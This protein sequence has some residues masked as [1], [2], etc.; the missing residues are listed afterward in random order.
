MTSSNSYQ[1]GIATSVDDIILDAFERCGF[2]G[3]MISGLQMQ[4]ARRSLNFLFSELS[5]RQINL[6][7][8][9]QRILGL[10]TNQISYQ[11]PTGLIDIANMTRRQST[12][13]LG[14]TAYTSAGGTASNAFDGD[15]T[16]SCT[17]TSTN[18]YIYYD[19]GAGVTQAISMVGFIPNVTASYTLAFKYSTDAVT[20]T[21]EYTAS[22]ETLTAGQQYW[23]AMPAPTATR[24]FG[25]FETGGGTM[26]AVE[27]YLN[28]IT[29]DIVMSRMSRQEYIALPDKIS[30]GIP[31]Q[32]YLDRQITPV[33]NIWKPSD[34]TYQTIYYAAMMQI[35]DVT[36][37]T[38]TLNMPYRFMEA[39]S[40]GLAAKLA[41]KW[42]PDRAAVLGPMA[43]R[44][45]AIAAAE[46]SEGVPVRFSPDM[47]GY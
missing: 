4:S 31:T 9:S 40:A 2:P 41:V 37:Y 30:T 15:L 38:Q 8:V 46:D 28:Q 42:A 12:R 27:I 43:E 20:W 10:V 35:Q 18:G 6:W 26:D 11:M 36:N 13:V 47:T 34:G 45:Y 1:F 14:G 44:S 39:I 23:Y 24:Y 19:F 33:L 17:Q 29:S 5:S 25:V 21:T 32:F 22:A 3:G 7:T 16:T